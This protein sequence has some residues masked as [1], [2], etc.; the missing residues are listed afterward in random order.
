MSIDWSLVSAG[1]SLDRG[2]D[3]VWLWLQWSGD[4]R[5]AKKIDGLLNIHWNLRNALKY[6][7][8]WNPVF[9]VTWSPATAPAGRTLTLRPLVQSAPVSA[10][11][12]CSHTRVS[13][14]RPGGWLQRHVEARR[15]RCRFRSSLAR[16]AGVLYVIC[17]RMNKAAFQQHNTDSIDISQTCPA[18]L[19]V[20]M[21]RAISC[22]CSSTR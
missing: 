17:L 1:K 8:H 4:V 10:N 22:H 5:S 15:G 7:A 16:S 6:F 13:D 19:L 3:H 12:I 21:L 9:A 2:V 14:L 18:R 11:P 20:I